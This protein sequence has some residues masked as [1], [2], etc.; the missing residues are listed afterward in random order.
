MAVSLRNKKK[1]TKLSFKQ[2]AILTVLSIAVILLAVTSYLANQ[3]KKITQSKADETRY[4]WN[5]GQ[6]IKS[7]FAKGS[8]EYGDTVNKDNYI[9]DKGNSDDCRKCVFALYTGGFPYGQCN[10]ANP[11]VC[12]SGNV[13]AGCS[14]ICNWNCCHINWK[15]AD[16]KWKPTVDGDAYDAAHPPGGE[17]TPIGGGEKPPPEEPKPKATATPTPTTSP[18]APYVP[19]I[20]SPP[21]VP[22]V[23]G[24]WNFQI[25]Y[26]CAAGTLVT[27]DTIVRTVAVDAQGNLGAWSDAYTYQGSTPSFSFHMDTVTGQTQYGI[28]VGRNDGTNFIPFASSKGTEFLWTTTTIPP[29]SN[30]TTLDYTVDPKWCSTG[31]IGPNITPTPDPGTTPSTLRIDLR[32]IPRIRVSCFSSITCKFEDF[33][34]DS[35]APFKIC[36]DT[37]RTDCSDVEIEKVDNP[38]DDDNFLQ[39]SLMII[40]TFNS[41]AGKAPVVLVNRLDTGFDLTQLHAGAK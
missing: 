37:S 15:T 33:V 36:F 9:S 16:G 14:G 31:G 41:K 39:Y 8:C 3:P 29:S 19:P 12:R 22:P 4:C 7:G 25:N 30:V 21:I 20:V 26:K 38:Y 24:S 35:K 11:N 1:K 18:N 5:G 27:G 10:F 6:P 32:W 23:T 28:Q 2:I 13:A 17:K 34:N 40:L